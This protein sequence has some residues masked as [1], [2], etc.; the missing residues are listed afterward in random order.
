MSTNSV[1]NVLSQKVKRTVT[2]IDEERFFE[3]ENM[4]PP[5]TYNSISTVV[6]ELLFYANNGNAVYTSIFQLDS[7][8]YGKTFISVDLTLDEWNPLSSLS[9]LDGW[10]SVAQTLPSLEDIKPDEA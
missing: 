9:T 10:I 3:L 2:V 7:T 5:L 6:S 1:E 4:L 8:Q